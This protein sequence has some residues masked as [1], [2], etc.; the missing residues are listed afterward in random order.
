[1]NA[2]VSATIKK[3]LLIELN[4]TTPWY[5]DTNYE[6]VIVTPVIGGQ[7]QL[8]LCNVVVNYQGIN[9]PCFDP[10]EPVFIATTGTEPYDKVVWDLGRLR[11]AALRYRWSSCVVPDYGFEGGPCGPKYVVGPHK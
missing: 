11:N 6:L 5:S 3:P 9:V 8:K 7:P 10:G 1:M 4:V 2:S